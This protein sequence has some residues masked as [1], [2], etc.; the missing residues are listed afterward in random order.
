MKTNQQSYI[1][2]P[3][4]KE[5]VEQDTDLNIR[6]IKRTL[7]CEESAK[8]LL[9]TDPK[10]KRLIVHED[11]LIVKDGIRYLCETTTGSLGKSHINKQKFPNA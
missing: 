7:I 11:T 3:G 5:R 10:A 8:R 6:A 4:H 1:F 9:Q 2:F